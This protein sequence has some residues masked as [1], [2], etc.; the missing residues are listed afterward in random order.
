MPILLVFAL[1]IACLP[2]TWPA[3]LLGGEEDAAISFAVAAVG[4]SLTAALALRVWVVRTLRRDPMRKGHVAST[5]SR[6][7]RLMFFANIALVTLCV[8]VFGWGWYVQKTL[9]IAG[10]FDAAKKPLVAPFAELAVAL[11]YFL[12]LFGAWTIYYDAERAMHR[13][14]ILG[15]IDKPFWSRLGYFF[16]HLR[17][18]ALL[19]MLPVGLFVTQTVARL[20]PETLQETWY[21][22][23]TFSLIPL[24]IVFMP[25]LIKPLLGL[26]SMPPGPVRDRFEAL[27]K[28]LHFRCTDFLLWPT[29]GAAA[30]AMIV[31]LF[32]WVRYVI[33]TD[34]IL[35]DLTPEEVDGVFG[36][37]VGHAKHGHILLYFLV[38][39]LSVTVLAAVLVLIE[40]R[41][42]AA[43]VELPPW[44]QDWIA[45]PPVLV[46]A[47]YLFLVFGYLSRRCERQ[48]DVYGCRAVSCDAPNCA[49][50]DEQT[51]YPERARGLCRTGITTFM[52]ALER[53]GY[54]N[55]HTG[56]GDSHRP[57]S[58]GT[59]LRGLFAWLRAWQHSTM[60]RRIAFLQSLIG[61]PAKEARFQRSVLILRWGLILGLL[62]ALY[63]LGDTVGWDELLQV[64]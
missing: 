28:R 16:N 23:T 53:V 2:V 40:Q 12:I 43:H 64:L 11:P 37:E 4:L 20:S 49:G 14:S 61:N 46:M 57:R 31:G 9:V 50:H 18:F 51:R 48:A 26:K 42:R 32:P 25:L 36:H 55:G 19:V 27:A 56:D 5:Y 3:P 10:Q 24:L 47:S 59:M 22:L 54:I 30:N 17:Q 41:R 34:R 33:F 60:P 15:P 13:T 7:R 44:A 63:A 58:L 6:L 8:V 45:L 62:A 39:A 21:R 52:N 38:L 35:D 29:H 1:T